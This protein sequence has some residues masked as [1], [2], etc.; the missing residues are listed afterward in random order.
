MS[1]QAG[2]NG[3]IARVSALF[4]LLA[5]ST[6]N[7]RE[8]QVGVDACEFCRMA[9]SD[10][11]FGGEV[12]LTTGRHH[13]FDSI[14]CLAGF[15]AAQSDSTRIRGVWVSD[16]E[17]RRLVDAQ[18]AVFVRGGSVRSPMGRDVIAFAAGKDAAEL[19]NTY[20]GTVTTWAEV[21]AALDEDGVHPGARAAT[22]GDSAS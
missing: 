21:R 7:P 13:T 22:P 8:L 18:S 14:E 2:L 17:Q 16:F 3:S 12:L 10:D 15:L 11:R 20:G 5:C 19:R 6:G 1:R 4:V 9:I